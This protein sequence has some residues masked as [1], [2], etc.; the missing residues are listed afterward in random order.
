VLFGH[1][2]VLAAQRR[3]PKSL[4]SNGTAAAQQNASERHRIRPFKKQKQSA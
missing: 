4:I 3:E 2:H 1:A